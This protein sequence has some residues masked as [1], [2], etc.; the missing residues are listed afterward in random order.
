MKRKSNH[1]NQKMKSSNNTI[2]R[3]RKHPKK[4]NDVIKYNRKRI[5]KEYLCLFLM[6]IIIIGFQQNHLQKKKLIRKSEFFKRCSNRCDIVNSKP[7]FENTRSALISIILLRTNGNIVQKQKKSSSSHHNSD[8]RTYINKI[9]QQHH[10]TTIPI[11]FYKLWFEGITSKEYEE[12]TTSIF[13]KEDNRILS[14]ST[15]GLYRMKTMND[16]WESS[17]RWIVNWSGNDSW[18]E[19]SN[20]HISREAKVC[21]KTCVNNLSNMDKEEPEKK[22]LSDLLWSGLSWLIGCS[23]IHAISMY[24]SKVWLWHDSIV[25]IFQVVSCTLWLAIIKFIFHYISC[26]SEKNMD[27]RWLDDELKHHVKKGSI[28]KNRQG[29][30]GDLKFSLATSACYKDKRVTASKTSSKTEGSNS[31]ILKQNDIITTPTSSSK[32]IQTQKNHDD[33]DIAPIPT[34]VNSQSP[35]E[36]DS[37]SFSSSLTEPSIKSIPENNPKSNKFSKK[38]VVNKPRTVI[39]RAANKTN[40][41][42]TKTSKCNNASLLSNNPV[43]L[44]SPTERQREEALR[45]LREYQSDVKNVGSYRYNNKSNSLQ[46]PLPSPTI[47]QREEALRLL[48]EYQSAQISKIIKAR[49]LAEIEMTNDVHIA[50]FRTTATSTDWKQQSEKDSFIPLQEEIKNNDDYSFSDEL[51]LSNMLDDDDEKDD[52]S[53]S[54]SISQ[55]NT[56]TTS[57]VLTG[58]SK[59]NTG[60]S[61]IWGTTGFITSPWISS[62][63][64]DGNGCKQHDR[65]YELWSQS[66]LATASIAS[67]G[68]E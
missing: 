29:S 38:E 12:H 13:H 8:F 30:G 4:K 54:T 24:G 7:T 53:N 47:K 58:V 26:S 28:K 67:W 31:E 9:V 3:K 5:Y 56:L 59:S 44:P 37:E 21:R 23:Y 42:T 6:S 16:N 36:E 15:K 65:E 27:Y 17:L 52:L 20:R 11:I 62:S 55:P 61:S 40:R 25:F 63:S 1:N 45:L 51:L 35:Q 49:S 43:V 19:R 14:S 64:N 18:K 48:R 22:E 32:V 39:A 66:T 33:D 2:R 57:P 68:S 34:V 10:T 46:S 50:S 41:S 60:S